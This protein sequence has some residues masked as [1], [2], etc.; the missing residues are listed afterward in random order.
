MTAF[1]L[2]QGPR[3]WITHCCFSGIQPVRITHTLLSTH[4]IDLIAIRSSGFSYLKVP[5]EHQSQGIPQNIWTR[6]VEWPLFHLPAAKN[7]R[8]KPG[9]N[10]LQADGQRMTKCSGTCC[11][12]KDSFFHSKDVQV[13]SGCHPRPC[14]QQDLVKLLSGLH[15][16]SIPKSS[17]PCW[18]W[19]WGR[20]GSKKG[21]SP[22]F[23][24][25]DFSVCE[26]AKQKCPELSLGEAC[27]YPK[28][29][30]RIKTILFFH[31]W[32]CNRN[33]Q[34]VDSQAKFP[35]WLRHT[36]KKRKNRNCAPVTPSIVQ[37]MAKVEGDGGGGEVP[38]WAMQKEKSLSADPLWWSTGWLS[39]KPQRDWL[40]PAKGFYYQ[41]EWGH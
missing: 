21:T 16:P 3:L 27:L 33:D 39:R 2:Q 34:E 30:V 22:G 6:G 37:R 19:N 13:L 10:S 40:F 4:G 28:N 17:W 36:F 11:G 15:L 8:A 31:S 26:V 5:V 14:H 32:K 18:L 9:T 7:K 12:A 1:I 25:E 24:L 23:E 29:M 41:W 20:C 38:F 35:W